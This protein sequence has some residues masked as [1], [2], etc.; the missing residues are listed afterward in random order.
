M[1]S[2]L[3]TTWRM[4]PASLTV[5]LPHWDPTSWRAGTW[6]GLHTTGSPESRA[7]FLDL[8]TTAAGG[9]QFFVAGAILCP[10]E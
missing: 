3:D 7:R 5:C 8:S 10:V 6:S 4:G 9:R 2:L 1:S